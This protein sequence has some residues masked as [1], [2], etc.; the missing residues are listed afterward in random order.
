MLEV[1]NEEQIYAG[2]DGYAAHWQMF[3]EVIKG[4]DVYKQL[5]SG[6][7]YPLRPTLF[8]DT[9]SNKVTPGEKIEIKIV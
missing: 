3:N 7:M 2:A 6:Y 8:Q 1:G 4:S 5:L 9:G